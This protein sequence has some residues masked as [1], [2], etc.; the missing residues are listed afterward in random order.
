MIHLCINHQA[1]GYLHSHFIANS[2]L[3]NYHATRG[4]NKLHLYPVHTEVGKNSF[5]F[6]G[7]QDW[8]KLPAEITEIAGSAPLFK[9]H[10]KAYLIDNNYLS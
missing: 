6:K 5:R 8:N 1:P 3:P 9:K 10:L 2:A 7:A 4:Q